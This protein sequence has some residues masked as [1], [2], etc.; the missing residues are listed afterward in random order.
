MPGNGP[1]AGSGFAARK[2][3]S[4]VIEVE[5]QALAVN[6][7]ADRSSSIGVVLRAGAV[8]TGSMNADRAAKAASLS[9]D[10]KSRWIVTADSYLT[11]LTASLSPDGSS[12]GG[13]EGDGHS[14][15]YDAKANPWLGGKTYALEKGG[16]LVP[17]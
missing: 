2:G 6:L 16:S 1:G 3:G 5:G 4:S 15:H 13:I 9:L 17:Y 8:W 7:S 12:V 10:E 14:V 11:S